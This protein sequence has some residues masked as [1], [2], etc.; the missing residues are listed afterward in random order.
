MLE[1]IE[2]FESFVPSG[3]SYSS[4]VASGSAKTGMSWVLSEAAALEEES[5]S[6]EVGKDV[7]Y[8]SS[9]FDFSEII[10]YFSRGTLTTNEV[11]TSKS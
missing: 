10:S 8:S 9:K 7:N 4:L 3:E 1:S 5:M 6:S 11:F 2:T